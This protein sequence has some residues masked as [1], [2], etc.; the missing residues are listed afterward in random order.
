[1]LGSGHAQQGRA[2]RPQADRAGRESVKEDDRLPR[3]RQPNPW[4]QAEEGFVRRLV[5]THSGRIAGTSAGSPQR[6]TGTKPF[7][8]SFFVG[9]AFAVSRLP[10]LTYSAPTETLNG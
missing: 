1:M 2:R 9:I 7:P 6:A 3:D 8:A 5:L 4:P 10:S